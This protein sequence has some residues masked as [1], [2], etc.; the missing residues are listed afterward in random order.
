LLFQ[1]ALSNYPSERPQEELS[2][3][4][5]LWRGLSVQRRDLGG[6]RRLGDGLDG[7]EVKSARCGPICGLGQG[8]RGRSV[9]GNR[10]LEGVG[11]FELGGW[12]VAEGFMQAVVV[13]PRDPLHGCELEL[14]ARAPYAVGDQLGLIGIN[15]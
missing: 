9:A 10:A 14:R 2:S 11:V 4:A 6:D 12:D 13:K 3:L 7:G 5:C 15:E 1:R 8:R